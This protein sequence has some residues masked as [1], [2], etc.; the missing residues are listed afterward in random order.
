[1]KLRDLPELKLSILDL[2]QKEKDKLLLRLIAKDDVLVEQL[3]F[4]LLEDGTDLQ[5]RT[6]TVFQKIDELFDDST[7]SI[8][9]RNINT[10]QR[11][12]LLLQKSQSGLVNFH[13]Q[14]TKDKLSEFEL[15]VYIL[16]QSFERFGFLYEDKMTG[17]NAEKLLKYQQARL[18]L[19]TKL[20]Y[21]F[22]EDVQ[23]DYKNDFDF[24]S[25]F[26]N[27]LRD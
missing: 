18:Q 14:I 4:Q 11:L 24:I 8:N 10:G 26:I 6:Q 1:M 13:S 20:F 19:I 22:H 2:S 27:D 17:T 7:K 3:H 23:F 15:R 21:Q 16:K 9:P 5:E 12:L 25:T